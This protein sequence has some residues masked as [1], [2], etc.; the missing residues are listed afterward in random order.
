MRHIHLEFDDATLDDYERYYFAN[1]PRAK[2]KPIKHPYHESINQW[3]IMKRPEMNALKGRWKDFAVWFID[4]QGYSNLR[5]ERCEL[6]FR[7]YYGTNRRH[8]IDNTCPKFILDGLCESGLIVDD[9]CQHITKLTLMCGVD[10]QRPRTEIDIFY[11]DKKEEP[12]DGKE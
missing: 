3:M 2:K 10:R 6:T 4:Q 12:D 11:W 7:T 9:D 1:H 5:I 8:D